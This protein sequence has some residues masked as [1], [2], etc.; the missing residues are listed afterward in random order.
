MLLFFWRSLDR[1]EKNFNIYTLVTLELHL[2]YIHVTLNH[3]FN[4]K[5]FFF[6]N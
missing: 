6:D 3:K 4:I 5:I 1:F 2:C